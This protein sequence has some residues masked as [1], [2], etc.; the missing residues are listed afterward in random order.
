M[1]TRKWDEFVLILLYCYTLSLS[2]LWELSKLSYGGFNSFRMSFLY[3][4]V[5]ILFVSVR[6]C[7]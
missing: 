3:G 4:W 1:G 2:L 6:F 5:V 7:M